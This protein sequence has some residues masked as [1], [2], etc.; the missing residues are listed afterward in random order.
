MV[1]GEVAER[2]EFLV[3]GGGVGGYV[4]ALR[5]AELGAEVVLVERRGV[6]GLGGVCLHEGCIPSKALIEFAR[7]V[8]CVHQLAA[9]RLA[10]WRPD[11]IGAWER[12]TVA[13][14]R[15][16]EGIARRMKALNVT[17]VDGEARFNRRKRVAV[18]QGNGV[19]F[20]DFE[21]C[22]IA[23]GSRPRQLPLLP[24]DGD[25]VVDSTGALDLRVLPGRMVIV[26]GGYIGLELGTAYA[27]LGV[28]VTVVEIGPQL[29]PGL[30]GD[31][32]RPV[33]KGL[34]KLGV[35][36]LLSTRPVE[37]TSE[38]LLIAGEEGGQQVI[39]A[40]IVVVTAGRVPNTDDL[41]LHMADVPVTDDG[42]I[43]VDAKCL[44]R[45]GLAA[46]GDVTPGPAF[47]HR[48]SA[49][50][51]VAAESLLGHPTEFDHAT[52]PS[53][54]FTDPEIATTGLTLDTA[55]SMGIE[56]RAVTASLKASGRASALDTDGFARLVIDPDRDL[57]IGAQ[58]VSPHASDVISELTLAIELAA[59]PWDIALTVH[60][61]PT[62]SE[63]FHEAAVAA[64]KAPTRRRAV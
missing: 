21:R 36:I 47:A 40:D 9:G 62:F 53:V 15:L 45:P 52:I 18:Q 32:V 12:R 61:H 20:I 27:K 38:G 23:T 14:A 3:I 30:E 10:D 39:P 4:A 34:R 46:I 35:D 43:V 59:S 13:S 5:A 11:V 49:Q 31:L 48:A 22:V 37:L 60:P 26:G 25:R 63:S 55:R 44:V 16:A 29:L 42:L 51:I 1:V 24:V 8:E 28:H 57:V 58:V 33:R 7:Q 54:I 19:G 56:A 50:A 2:A 6:P 41:G 64:T 17:I